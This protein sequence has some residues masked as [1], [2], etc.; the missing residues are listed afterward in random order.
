MAPWA[1]VMQA[2]KPLSRRIPPL[3][4]DDGELK[5]ASV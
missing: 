3:P 5:W 4:P 2:R 1:S